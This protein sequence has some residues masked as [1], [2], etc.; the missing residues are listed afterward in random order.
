MDLS[1]SA[2]EQ[3]RA[4]QAPATAATGAGGLG[5]ALEKI[6]PPPRK[7]CYPG[8][9]SPWPPPLSTPIL[10]VNGAGGAGGPGGGGVIGV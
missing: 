7:N 1:V 5:A 2:I 9:V 8:H 10:G 4:K 3:P 6:S